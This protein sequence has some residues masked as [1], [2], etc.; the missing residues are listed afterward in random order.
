MLTQ[1]SDLD[2]LQDLDSPKNY[3]IVYIMTESTIFNH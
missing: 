1:W 2:A 3:N